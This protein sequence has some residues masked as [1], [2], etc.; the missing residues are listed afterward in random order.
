MGIEHSPI[1]SLPCRWTAQSPRRLRREG[2]RLADDL[3]IGVCARRQ[4]SASAVLLVSTDPAHS[5]SDISSRRSGGKVREP[6]PGLSALEIDSGRGH[7]RYI[8]DVKR[9]SAHVQSGDHP[10]GASSDRTG[11]G[12]T[13]RWKR[14]R[15]IA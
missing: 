1:G 12:V 3:F 9:T 6:Q 14:R 4:P 13:A 11:G 10:A 8:N 7:A 2:G 15:S 5:T